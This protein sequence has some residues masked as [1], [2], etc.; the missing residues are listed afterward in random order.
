MISKKY[1]AFY[2]LLELPQKKLCMKIGFDVILVLYNIGVY[3]YKT[4]FL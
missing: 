4:L 1:T 3:F 2:L